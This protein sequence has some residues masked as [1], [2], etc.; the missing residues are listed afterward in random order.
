[1]DKKEP[2]AEPHFSQ[3]VRQIMSMLVALGLVAAGGYLGFAT[4]AAVFWT[5]P[6]L[7]GAILAC[8]VL[9]VLFQ[10]GGATDAVGRLDRKLC[11]GA[12]RAR[13]R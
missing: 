10:A 13:P 3:P 2:E 1:M 4:I 11:Q 8:F 12:D 5:N 7:N 6:Y 9:A